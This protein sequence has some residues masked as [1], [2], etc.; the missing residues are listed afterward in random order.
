MAE[1][2]DALEAEALLVDEVGLGDPL[3]EEVRFSFVL[4]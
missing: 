3:V 2:V 1:V 4:F